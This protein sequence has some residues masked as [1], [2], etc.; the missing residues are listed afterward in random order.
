V[1]AIIIEEKDQNILAQ[2]LLHTILTT[3]SKSND[4]SE[5]QKSKISH[6]S[7]PDIKVVSKPDNKGS[8]SISEI[9]EIKKFV[10]FYPYEVSFKTIIIPN[11]NEMTPEAQNALLKTLEDHSATT[12]FVMGTNSRKNLLPTILSRCSIVSL[13]K[14]DVDYLAGEIIRIEDKDQSQKSLNTLTLGELDKI[15]AEKDLN[16]KEKALELLKSTLEEER[17]LLRDAIENSKKRQMQ[18]SLEKV[19][20]IQKLMTMVERNTNPKLVVER[21]IIQYI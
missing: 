9:K 19:K 13:K 6:F 10:A 16:K 17:I 11:A 4:L 21:F 18:N 7:H 8:I 12:F 2:K 20:L 14:E 15:F 1:A 3:Y 5:D